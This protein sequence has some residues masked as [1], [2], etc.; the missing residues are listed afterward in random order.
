LDFENFKKR[1]EFREQ[2]GGDGE[3]YGRPDDFSSR[4]G[5]PSTFATF[6]EVS[7]YGN[8]YATGSRSSSRT[9][10]GEIDE[11]DQGVSYAPGYR[12]APPAEAFVDVSIPA[13][14]LDAEEVLKATSSNQPLVGRQEKDSEK[15]DGG[16]G[17]FNRNLMGDEDT[18]YDHF[19]A[20]R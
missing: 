1:A 8:R 4:P 16:A 17:Y 3:L 12:Q 6:T 13:T 20:S 14:P 18:S 5:T 15:N 11:T 7:P 9:R 10:L 19:R 2:F